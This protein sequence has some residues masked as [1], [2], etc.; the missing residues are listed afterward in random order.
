MFIVKYR[1]YCNYY[2]SK[3]RAKL[4]RIVESYQSRVDLVQK[5]SQL[6]DEKKNQQD[7]S[8]C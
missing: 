5:E 7:V 1:T 4:R 8:E 2:V 3:E 6:K